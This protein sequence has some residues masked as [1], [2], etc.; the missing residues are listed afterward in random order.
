[1]LPRNMAEMTKLQEEEVIK[2]YTSFSLSKLRKYQYLTNL[3][4]GI[5]YKDRKSE[6]LE[7]LQK[8]FSLLRVAVDRKEF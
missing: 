6:V 5:A 3:Q 1:M 2:H 4:I 7:S 8:Q